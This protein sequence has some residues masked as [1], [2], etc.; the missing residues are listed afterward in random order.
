MKVL[1]LEGGYLPTR[2]STHSAGYD[3]KATKEYNL[4]N[5]LKKIPIGIKIKLPDNHYGHICCRSSLAKRGCSIEAGIIDQDYRGEICV[6]LRTRETEIEIKKGD[7]IA[8]LLV[9]PCYMKEIE[10]VSYLDDTERGEGGFGST[11]I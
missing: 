7:R 5:T 6:M 9:I 3:L 10:Q 4:K 11:G 1:L 8:Q 2:G